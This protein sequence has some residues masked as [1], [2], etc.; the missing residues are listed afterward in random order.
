MSDKWTH[1]K[2]LWQRITWWWTT[3]IDLVF[4]RTTDPTVY[5]TE[6]DYTVL[7]YTYWTTKYYRRVYKTYSADTDIFYTDDTLTTAVVTRALSF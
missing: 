4:R 5:A 2:F 6:D 7:E 3:R 1:A